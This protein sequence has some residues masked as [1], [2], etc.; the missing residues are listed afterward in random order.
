V[1][2]KSGSVAKRSKHEVGC[3]VGDSEG[4]KVGAGLGDE[5]GENDGALQPAHVT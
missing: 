1:S 3:T 4:R 2:A 5:V